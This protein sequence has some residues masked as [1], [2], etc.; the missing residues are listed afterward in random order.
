MSRKH[1]KRNSLKE[2]INEIKDRKVNELANSLARL[3]KK[4]K[5]E[6][7]ET[8]YQFQELDDISG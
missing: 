1:K 2:V 4:R 6:N 8:N 5:N 3:N 7:V